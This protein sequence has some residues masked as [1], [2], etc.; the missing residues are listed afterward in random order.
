MESTCNL[1]NSSSPSC[2]P[3]DRHPVWARDSSSSWASRLKAVVA[4]GNYREGLGVFPPDKCTCSSL[5]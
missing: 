5:P 1:R 4:T 2:T 3:R